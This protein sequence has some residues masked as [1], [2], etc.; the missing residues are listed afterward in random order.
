MKLSHKLMGLVIV[1]LVFELAFVTTLVVL[2]HQAEQEAI[3]ETHAKIVISKCR[4]LPD[5]CFNTAATLA[6]LAVTKSPE[7]QQRYAAN[8]KRMAS[9]LRTIEILVHDNPTQAQAFQKMQKAGSAGINVLEQYRARIQTGTDLP[10]FRSVAGIRGTIQVAVDDLMTSVRDLVQDE[11]RIS[12]VAPLAKMRMRQELL[13]LLIA[14]VIFNCILAL[15]LA[16]WL[17][18]VTVKR[19]NILVD[20]TRRIVKKEPLLPPMIGSDEISDLDSVFHDMADAL[21]RAAK[22]KQ[23]LISMV[24]HDL[25][26]PLMSVQVSL[27]LIASGAIGPLQQKMDREVKSASRN[28]KRLIELIN[29]LLDIEKMEAGRLDMYITQQ[30]ILALIDEAIDSVRAS[31]EAKQITVE[32]PLLDIKVHVDK[33]RIIQ[34]LVNL[35][36]NAIKFSPPGSKITIELDDDEK[37]TTIK[38]CDQGSGIAKASQETIFDRF[39]QAAETGSGQQ[40]GSVSSGAAKQSGIASHTDRANKGTGLGLAICKAIIAGHDGRI[41]VQSEEG[42]GSTFWFSLPKISA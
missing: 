40:G 39:H 35:L 12:E 8:I 10:D 15:V 21:D 23:E 5:L 7:M 22:H 20:N 17:N 18:R 4:D 19:L 42:K 9:D 41:G 1:P 30:S 2:L 14:F 13:N 38:V 34:V 36:S 33:Q 29:D 27:E 26:S 24:S 37:E 16:L 28:V 25:R 6:G 31:S 3:T 11:R 32:R